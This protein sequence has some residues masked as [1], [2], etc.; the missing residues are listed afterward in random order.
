LSDRVG[1]WGSSASQFGHFMVQ[2][3]SRPS[4]GCVDCPVAETSIIVG[5]DAAAGT[6]PKGP[7]PDTV[8]R[9]GGA[10]VIY[11]CLNAPYS[12]WPELFP[13]LQR[14]VL[15][16]AERTDALLV[17][18]ENVYGYGPIAGKPMTDRVIE[19]APG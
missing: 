3:S 19:R 8:T 12:Q 4:T 16:A 6:E 11:Q 2:D 9:Y 14:G 13:P 18:L 7:K 1:G 10:S 15:S 17:T 5:P